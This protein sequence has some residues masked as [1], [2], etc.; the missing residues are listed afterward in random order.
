M[1]KSFSSRK[2]IS[3]LTASAF[4]A[5]VGIVAVAT[6][7]N[8]VWSNN[9]WDATYL[10]D[11]DTICTSY[12][13]G[14][15]HYKTTSD[16]VWRFEDGDCPTI[17]D[18]YFDNGPSDAFDQFGSVTVYESAGVGHDF[19]LYS[20]GVSSSGGTMTYKGYADTY[21][22]VKIE[23]QLVDQ[24]AT[25]NVS[26][27][28]YGTVMTTPVPKS[29]YQIQI[30]GNLG[31]DSGH[32]INAD[33]T[34]NKFFV[35]NGF[36]SGEED[37][38][39]EVVMYWDPGTGTFEDNLYDIDNVAS[40][41]GTNVN[42][43]SMSI[44]AFNVSV[45]NSGGTDAFAAARTQ[46]VSDPTRTA[47]NVVLSSFCPPPP[48]P[49]PVDVG[50]DFVIN[51][52]GGADADGTDGIKI[53]INSDE[54]TDYNGEDE[55]SL[56]PSSGSDQI[57][58]AGKSN[59]CCGGI[60]PSLNIGGVL[61]GVS[62]A[63]N[64]NHEEDW[65]SI[66]VSSLT[67]S[68]DSDGESSN[69]GDGGLVVTYTATIDDLDY[70][71]IRTI[72]YTS[73]NRYFTDAYSIVVPTGNTERVRF[74]M[75]GDTAPGTDDSGFGIV[76]N[77]NLPSIPG[78]T[79]MSLNPN[80]S[81]GMFIAYRETGTDYFDGFWSQDYSDDYQKVADGA[82][83]GTS[84]ADNL[85]T[86]VH[87]AGIMM[88]WNL[89][90]NAAVTSAGTYTRTVET[91][92]DRYTSVTASF[93]NGTTAANFSETDNVTTPTDA[94]IDIALRT[95]QVSDQTNM[96][97]VMDLPT[98]VTATGAATT[99]CTEGNV[100]RSNGN[101]TLTG[102][103]I[104]IPGADVCHF[105]V[106]V[107]F[108]SY[109]TYAL[110]PEDTVA[111][112]PLISLVKS[113]AE[114]SVVPESYDCS[115]DDPIILGLATWTT[116]DNCTAAKDLYLSNTGD[117]F[118]DF[119][120]VY[121]NDGDDDFLFEPTSTTAVKTDTK[122]VLTSRGT[123]NNGRD[124]ADVKVVV[125]FENNRVT[126]QVFTYRAG[127]LTP[128]AVESVKVAGALGS[129]EETTWESDFTS[130]SGW[131][132][133]NFDDGDP[134][135]HWT[136]DGQLEKNQSGDD[137]DTPFSSKDKTSA[138]TLSV[139][140]FDYEACADIPAIWAYAYGYVAEYPTGTTPTYV[141]GIACSG[142]PSE[143]RNLS[144]D[145]GDGTATVT[146]DAPLTDGG[147]SI[148][149]YEYQLD[150]GRWI[151]FSPSITSSP[152]VITG[153]DN[154]RTYTIR[155]RAVNSNGI[156]LKAAIESSNG[157]NPD[158]ATEVLDL[159]LALDLNVGA[160]VEG[161]KSTLLGSN[162]KPTSQYQ[163]I[164]QSDP[165]VLYT[166]TTDPNGNINQL[167]TLPS[168]C[169]AKGKHT[170]SLVG[171]RPDGTKAKAVAYLAFDGKCRVLGIVQGAT[172]KSAKFGGIRFGYNSA[173]LSKVSKSNIRSMSVLLTD[174]KVVKVY[175]YTQTNLKSA[176]SKKA[177]KALAKRRA[178][179][180]KAYLK[181]LGV[182][183]KIEIVAVGAKKPV[184]KK[185][186]YKNRRVTLKMQYLLSS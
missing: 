154:D 21:A 164:M 159:S 117:A 109:G 185:K 60:G 61:Y 92:V 178:A 150:D 90:S 166:G 12:S 177:N 9:S 146:F 49:S 132:S 141:P 62:G 102:S 51:G 13:G 100:D 57:F 81:S 28:N 38:S 96:S 32:T 44:L 76:L 68:A 126:W 56:D 52:G 85:N 27:Y 133:D 65:S 80:P 161:A 17:T 3:M 35:H 118:D 103:G 30:Y 66:S 122:M 125:T 87:D 53:V 184:S 156:G 181:K 84:L 179:S 14:F 25:W 43:Y 151:S 129:D 19:S 98:G 170:L 88:Q 134:V 101:A 160:K 48:P 58:L 106:P 40:T 174:A 39:N 78:K 138:L 163:L 110:E 137:F 124:Y 50:D 158:E 47:T 8:A 169:P 182:T 18:L 72:S 120:S 115:S 95:S 10:T 20:G 127:T 176:S 82:E 22:D 5:S 29:V 142:T 112:F 26:T 162:L 77:K 91:M 128:K 70:Q 64:N 67:G 108:A 172:L 152:A 71:L 59:V 97:F 55:E 136:T 69:E 41:S 104:T 165:V 16:T 147:S 186:Q 167:I 83:L 46:L 74:Y 42:T 37:T 107:A 93:G 63:A 1:F 24:K 2:F 140:A 54:E 119:G 157:L 144:V 139:L 99:T 130:T 168:V 75:G 86:Q 111:D 73:P 45:C 131:S 33:E 175:G 183:A 116:D 94:A 153:L 7:A 15:G 123:I 114:Y 11:L 79:L 113:S 145:R 23:I 148:T 36:L 121:I 105:V 143:P 155:L 171:T 89:D 31:T 4:A 34:G 6:P 173:R 180:V 149:N 135:L